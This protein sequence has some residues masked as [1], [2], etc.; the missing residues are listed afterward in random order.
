MERQ[1]GRDI[2]TAL[3]AGLGCRNV[4]VAEVWP[5]YRLQPWRAESFKFSA[6]P[7]LRPR[8]AANYSRTA[9]LVKESRS[10]DIGQVGDQH[11][12]VI[13]GFCQC[14]Y[15]SNPRRDPP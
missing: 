6:D 2:T 11:L 1:P 14:R 8:S 9:A 13:D 12:Y 4:K 5:E 3:A 7:Q 15:T 10:R